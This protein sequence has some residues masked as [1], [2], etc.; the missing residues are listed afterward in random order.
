MSGHTKGPW[1]H[2]DDS[3]RAIPRHT[4]VA[5]GKTV[6]TVYC[7]KGQEDED[8]ANARL[9]AAAPCMRN[10][11]TEA[12]TTLA[13]LKRN[14]VTEIARHDGLLRWEGVPEA[15]QARIDECDAAITRADGG[16]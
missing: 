4:V 14:V 8:A 2:Y 12:R 11:L 5:A 9:I 10:A 3:N 15:I 1:V 16:E 13:M 7:T 6:T